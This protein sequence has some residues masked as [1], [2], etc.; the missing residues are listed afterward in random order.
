MKIVNGTRHGKKP[1]LVMLESLKR[2]RLSMPN[3]GVAIGGGG[4]FSIAR[5]AATAA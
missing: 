4:R 3:A 1:R 2:S 5:A